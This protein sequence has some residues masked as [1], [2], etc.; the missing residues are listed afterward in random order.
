MCCH[1]DAGRHSTTP[2]RGGRG[3]AGGEVADRLT[4]F[5]THSHTKKD[6]VCLQ[7]FLNTHTHTHTHTQ[8]SLAT[9]TAGVSFV[10]N[11]THT[12]YSREVEVGER[13]GGR[14]VKYH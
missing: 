12:V 4:P 9:K 10:K 8:E 2:G 7:S 3:R 11:H 1:R 5:H 6:I 14:E 13:D